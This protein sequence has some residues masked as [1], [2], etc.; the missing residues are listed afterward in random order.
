MLVHLADLCYRHR[1]MV[2]AAWIITLLG[3]YLLA[4][5]FGGDVKQDYLQRGSESKAAADVLT[6]SF[7]L[8]SGDTIQVVIHS[9]AGVASPEVRAR[10]E[11]IFADVAG[12]A[13]VAS[14][15]SP[16]SPEGAGQISA[17]GRTAYA[18]VALDRSL[19]LIHI[20]EPTRPY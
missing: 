11:Q 17:D 10:A 20:S 7:P 5:A 4:G 18:E 15:V 2:V 3:A 12:E 9:P 19:S 6:T 8:R 1:R 13:H 16:F 14:V